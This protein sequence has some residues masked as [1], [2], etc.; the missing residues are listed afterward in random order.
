MTGNAAGTSARWKPC[1]YRRL[2]ELAAMHTKRLAESTQP[3]IT[4]TMAEYTALVS[5]IEAGRSPPGLGGKE[6]VDKLAAEICAVPWQTPNERGTAQWL[7]IRLS[8]AI[9]TEP[10]YRED[11]ASGAV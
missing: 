3:V 6:A 5:A 2:R 9:S 1:S 4:R 8:L 7:V 10:I 11:A